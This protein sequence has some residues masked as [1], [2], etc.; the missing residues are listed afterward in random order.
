MQPPFSGTTTITN[1]LNRKG[2]TIKGKQECHNMGNTFSGAAMPNAF[3]P[4]HNWTTTE[5]HC[6][7]PQGDGVNLCTCADAFVPFRDGESTQM[8]GAKPLLRRAVSR[9]TVV[10]VST[11]LSVG[12]RCLGMRTGCA[13]ELSRAKRQGIQAWSSTMKA[14][15]G[16]QV[17]CARHSS[18]LSN[19]LVNA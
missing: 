16:S 18:G 4:K 7:E 9:R 3:L 19:R 5:F 10:V 12:F 1:T 6:I 13:T 14:R 2:G 11:T 8:S 17:Q 15:A